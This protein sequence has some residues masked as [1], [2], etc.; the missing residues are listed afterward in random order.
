MLSWIRDL[1]TAKDVADVVYL[2]RAYV[3]AM[4]RDVLR[5]LPRACTDRPLERSP[6]VRCWSE[7]LSEEYWRRR[8]T[9]GDVDSLAEAWGFFLRASVQLGRVAVRDKLAES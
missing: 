8:A 7:R 5:E 2:A 6:D 1:E 4:P 9:G 3:A